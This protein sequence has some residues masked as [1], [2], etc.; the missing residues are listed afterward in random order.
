[1]G[2]KKNVPKMPISLLSVVVNIYKYIF[3][4]IHILVETF[5]QVT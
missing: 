4:D 1:M 2:E 5:Q 3:L